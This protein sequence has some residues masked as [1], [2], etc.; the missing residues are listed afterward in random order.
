[1]ELVEVEILT[2]TVTSQYGVLSQGDILRTSPEFA[3]HLVEDA[4]AAKY[5]K[6]KAPKE[7]A[8]EAAAP[9]KGKSK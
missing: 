7:P 2:Q 9:A 4:S 8:A 3:K 6:A 1:M 5:T